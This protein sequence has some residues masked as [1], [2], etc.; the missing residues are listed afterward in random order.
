MKW[1]NI[2]LSCSYRKAPILLMMLFTILFTACSDSTSSVDD[3]N[4]G[5]DEIGTEPV[6]SNIQQIFSQNCSTCHIRDRTSGVRLNTY[7]NAIE[8]VGD[9]YGR[10][11][12][13]PGDAD[14]SP[15]VDKIEPDPQ[16]GQR[17]PR[18]GPFLSQKRIKQIKDWIDDGAENN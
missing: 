12:I 17:M 3:N 6:F 13:Q 10:N 8:S 9:Q 5:S 2:S 11:V 14:G 1:K 7:E 4:N 15:L 16:F 18:G